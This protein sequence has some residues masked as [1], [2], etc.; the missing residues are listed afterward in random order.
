MLGSL[1][2]E[3]VTK[4]L[5]GVCMC[6]NGWIDATFSIVYVVYV[7]MCRH[8]V[9]VGW[10]WVNKMSQTRWLQPQP[11]IFSQFWRLWLKIN[12]SGGLV[13]CWHLSLVWWQPPSFW[14]LLWP[15]LWTPSY[16]CLFWCP[17]LLFSYGHQSDWIMAPPNGPHFN[18]ITSSRTCLQT[19]LTFRGTR[20]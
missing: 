14:V 10:H 20:D 9:L 5:W 4:N 12:M 11:F 17:G 18:F 8:T 16:W 3:K 6:M 19:P 13:C 2:L 15:F 7:W 1:K